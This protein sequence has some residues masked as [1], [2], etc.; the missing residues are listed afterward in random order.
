[1][2]LALTRGMKVNQTADQKKQNSRNSPANWPDPAETED[3]YN[4]MLTGNSLKPITKKKKKLFF[5]L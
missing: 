5:F 3:R 2:L 1:M 4:M